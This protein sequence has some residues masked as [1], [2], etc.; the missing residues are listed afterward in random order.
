MRVTCVL[1]GPQAGPGSGVAAARSRRRPGQ[2][3]RPDARVRPPLPPGRLFLRLRV[4]VSPPVPGVTPPWRCADPSV[5]PRAAG[6]RRAWAARVPAG[7]SD[8]ARGAGAE[9]LRAGCEL[10]G[11]G[12]GTR[13][14]RLQPAT[15]AFAQTSCN[16][17]VMRKESASCFP[18]T[19]RSIPA[20]R[21]VWRGARL[22][23][24]RACR[25]P[26]HEWPRAPRGAGGEA[27]AEEGG[28]G[29]GE[30]FLWLGDGLG[31]GPVLCWE[32]AREG[33]EADSVARRPVP[34]GLPRPRSRERPWGRC[35]EDFRAPL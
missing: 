33:R 21:G 35:S 12:A 24:P 8:L 4:S 20:R 7:S 2:R 6:G 28:P 34:G 31:V 10:P 1:G 26:L 3:L 23:R 5:G 22:S 30:G 29:R 9:G 18:V 17:E 14:L 27:G 16:S 25:R 32:R 11:R 15:Q 19:L 13:G